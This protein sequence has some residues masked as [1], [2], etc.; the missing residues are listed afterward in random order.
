MSN[1]NP[2]EGASMSSE[3]DPVLESER[4]P[5]PE[6]DRDPVCPVV[7]SIREEVR[8]LPWIK[9][10]LLLTSVIPVLDLAPVPFPLALPRP[11]A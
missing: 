5:D 1:S 10:G 7:R 2:G 9:S 6:P 4:D 11:E 3:I 8:S